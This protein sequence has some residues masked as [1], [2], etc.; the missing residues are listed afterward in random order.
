M[1]IRKEFMDTLRLWKAMRA[2]P[3]LKRAYTKIKMFGGERNALL[4]LTIKLGV[5][6]ENVIKM[7]DRMRN[8]F[9]QRRAVQQTIGT[10]NQIEELTEQMNLRPW[11]Q[12]NIRLR[13]PE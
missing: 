3:E 10:L 2:N 11:L 13:A 8:R 6:P 1:P 9:N 4:L 5:P 7:Y 12:N